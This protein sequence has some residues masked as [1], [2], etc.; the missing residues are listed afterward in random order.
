MATGPYDHMDVR[1]VCLN[2]TYRC[3]FGC[4]W[5]DRQLD[6]LKLDDS[7]VTLEQMAETAELIAST[8][9]PLRKVRVSGGEPREHPQFMEVMEALKP[10][11]EKCK[12]RVSTASQP[13]KGFPKLPRG[14]RFHSNP[15]Q[16]KNHMPFMVSPDDLSI[17]ATTNSCR[18]PQTCGMNYDKW[19][20]CFCPI[21]SV[22]SQTIG[23][24]VHSRTPVPNVM[25]WRI[26][27]HCIYSLGLEARHAVQQD[28]MKRNI[29]MPSPTFKKVLDTY[30]KE[31]KLVSKPLHLASITKG[32]AIAKKSNPQ[33]FVDTAEELTIL[34]GKGSHGGYEDLEPLS[35]STP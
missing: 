16:T 13:G 30:R 5:C 3:S 22:M 9:W 23:P 8:S 21:G 27:K 17:R 18:V 19:G 33:R 4:V 2:I 15:P 29:K 12:V 7:D 26:C 20:W 25:D 24:N 10:I 28:V 32:N 14:M 6:R 1:S 34:D 31:G 35:N 11:T